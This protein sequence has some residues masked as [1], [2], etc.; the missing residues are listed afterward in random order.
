M[1][2]SHSFFNVEIGSKRDTFHLTI[3]FMGQ[4]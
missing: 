4:I 2:T 1:F 3:D